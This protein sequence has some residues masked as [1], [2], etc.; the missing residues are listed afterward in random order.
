[1][2]QL[3]GFQQKEIIWLELDGTELGD[4]VEAQILLV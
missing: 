4:R 1:M 3:M 2:T